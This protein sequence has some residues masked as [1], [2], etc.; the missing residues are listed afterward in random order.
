[1]DCKETTGIIKTWEDTGTLPGTDLT[2][3]RQHI[4]HCD[5]GCRRYLLL[6][7]LLEKDCGQKYDLAPT[8]AETG[9]S[10]AD[11]VMARINTKTPQ[12]KKLNWLPAAAAAILIL[13]GA[14]FL[15]S[16]YR[17]G[18]PADKMVVRFELKAAE[19]DSVFLVGDFSNWDPRQIPLQGPDEQGIWRVKIRLEKHK[20]YTY[21]FLIDEE[22]WMPDPDA[23]LLVNDGFG[24]INSIINL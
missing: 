16:P 19:A 15:F 12:R 24:G 18:Q 4:T 17:S 14:I 22:I 8:S 11:R 20:T 3:L 2:E 9:N 6:I 1:M 23:D 13:T 5:R 10:V 7:P 21:N